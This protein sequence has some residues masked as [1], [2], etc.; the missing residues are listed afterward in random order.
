MGNT[1]KKWMRAATLM[2]AVRIL[3]RGFLIHAQSKRITMNVE[4]IRDPQDIGIVLRGMSAWHR[5]LND[6]P[7]RALYVTKEK[8][9]EK[10]GRCVVNS[11]CNNINRF[12]YLILILIPI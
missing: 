3:N 9:G 11:W 10:I 6:L 2:K 8:I 5:E 12:I 4:E 7:I 1:T